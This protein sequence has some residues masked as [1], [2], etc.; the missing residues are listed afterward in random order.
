LLRPVREDL[1]LLALTA[2]ALG[3]WLLVKGV[4][5]TKWLE[6]NAAARTMC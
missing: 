3:L 6:T 1:A 2:L 5:V 4:D